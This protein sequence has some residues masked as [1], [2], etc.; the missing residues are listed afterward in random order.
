MLIEVPGL[1]S[2]AALGKAV[3]DYQFEVQQARDAERVLAAT[4]FP[5]G[6]PVMPMKGLVG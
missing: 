2:T 4:V 6:V 5:D 1:L 3:F